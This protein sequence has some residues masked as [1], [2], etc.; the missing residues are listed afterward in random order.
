MLAAGIP[1]LRFNQAANTDNALERI[2]AVDM[3]GIACCKTVIFSNHPHLID[4]SFAT[5]HCVPLIDLTKGGSRGIEDRMT[6]RYKVGW[7]YGPPGHPP[8][9][10][11]TDGRAF[12]KAWRSRSLCFRLIEFTARNTKI[13]R[14]KLGIGHYGRIY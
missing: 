9:I 6:R 5:R 4:R 14:D 11:H 7:I 1:Y 12:T 13:V 2:S 10:R 8:V 3:A